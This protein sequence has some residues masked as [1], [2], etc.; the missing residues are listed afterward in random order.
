MVGKPIKK[1][2]N[3]QRPEIESGANPIHHT[4]CKLYVVIWYAVMVCQ[5]QSP[6]RYT[7]TRTRLIPKAHIPTATISC[8][9]PQPEAAEVVRETFVKRRKKT[10]AVT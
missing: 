4:N 7:V 1:I 10:G 3:V 8:E 5:T 2:F 9:T 6:L